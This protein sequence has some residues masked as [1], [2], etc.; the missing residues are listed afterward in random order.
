MVRAALY[1]GILCSQIVSSPSYHDYVVVTWGCLF[2]PKRERERACP[3]LPPETPHSLFALQVLLMLTS[4]V[5]FLQT[6][7]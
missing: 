3:K 4:V 7:V 2:N 6:A 1:I 5:L